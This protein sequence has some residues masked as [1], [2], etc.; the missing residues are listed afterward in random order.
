[1]NENKGMTRRQFLK[2]ALAGAAG[3][4]AVSFFGPSVLVPAKAEGEAAGVAA[5]AA[6]PFDFA[7][8]TVLLNNG[9]EMPVLGLGT[10]GLSNEQAENSAY[11]ISQF[12]W[13]CFVLPTQ[14]PVCRT[15]GFL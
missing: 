15:F 9:I 1:M 7:R 11:A 5:V 14:A 8:R 12:C 2:G 13:K 4:A 6:N 10:F 3:L